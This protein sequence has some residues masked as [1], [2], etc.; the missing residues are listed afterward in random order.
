MN[1]QTNIAAAVC[2]VV[3][4]QALYTAANGLSWVAAIE[5]DAAGGHLLV[6][7]PSPMARIHWRI[8]AVSSDGRRSTMDEHTAAARAEQAAAYPPRDDTAELL[9]R[10]DA[11]AAERADAARRDLAARNEGRDRKSVVSGRGVSRRVD[12][13]G[14]RTLQ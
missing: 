7:G 14:R 1:A 6:G 9:A 11:L 5:P 10:A 8:V 12:L 2:P 3:I 13:G 4:G